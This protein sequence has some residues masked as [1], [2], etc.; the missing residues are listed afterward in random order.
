MG[1]LIS[2]NND[3]SGGGDGEQMGYK[4]ANHSYIFYTIVILSFTII[5][6]VAGKYYLN[7]TAKEG[8]TPVTIMKWT[9]IA[10][11]LFFAIFSFVLSRYFKEREYIYIPLMIGFCI[12]LF[13][14]MIEFG[15]P[16]F[17]VGK[18]R[19]YFVDDDKHTSYTPAVALLIY[20]AMNVGM[21][22]YSYKEFKD[23]QFQSILNIS[24]GAIFLTL[25]VAGVNLII[26]TFNNSFDG[27]YTYVNG[28]LPSKLGLKVSEHSADYEP[29]EM[30]PM[31]DVSVVE[32]GI[33]LIIAS[34]YKYIDDITGGKSK[35][36][37][38]NP[39]NK[40][41]FLL[42]ITLSILG[43][44]L[45][46]FGSNIV[47]KYVPNAR[48]NSA[49]IVGCDLSQNNVACGTMDVDVNCK[50][51]CNYSEI[52]KNEKKKKTINC[53]CS[54]DT[55]D[56][57]D[58]YVGKKC[59]SD[60]FIELFD[61]KYYDGDTPDKIKKQKNIMY[62]FQSSPYEQTVSVFYLLIVF[63]TITLLLKRYYKT[64]NA[65]FMFGILLLIVIYTAII[66]LVGAK[67]NNNNII[68]MISGIFVVIFPSVITS[69]FFMITVMIN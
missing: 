9:N 52:K 41:M 63:S 66:T 12:I 4:L 28:N 33:P 14:G 39:D 47:K 22:I 42:I 35:N 20:I 32:L 65:M 8:S 2:N 36:I 30:F 15:W 51:T 61:K 29:V 37:A 18:I 16:N 34:Y 6:A 17:L 19:P 3:I 40:P 23:N 27:I 21:F 67:S 1:N 46:R 55:N 50:K 54:G 64:E 48:P 58:G 60:K 45:C 24:M 13:I 7:N 53:M 57:K 11:I 49:R 59:N 56:Y 44:I 69:I 38:T 10:F 25:V 31:S 26:N 5:K 68:S 43:S 62:A